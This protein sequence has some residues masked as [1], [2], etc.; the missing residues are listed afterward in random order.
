[1]RVRSQV[2]KR[3]A[4]PSSAT[5]SF[6]WAS[7]AGVSLLALLLG[8]AT[9]PAQAQWWLPQRKP[10]QPDQQALSDQCEK[11]RAWVTSVPLGSG[12]TGGD[13]RPPMPG[14]SPSA[15]RAL[16]LI[17]DEVFQRH[18]GKTYDQL[19][20]TDL[21]SFS[22][23]TGRPC[24]EQGRFTPLD[25]SMVHQLLN[26][27][28]QPRYAQQLIQHRAQKA[29][30]EKELEQLG[31][32]LARLR[33][34]EAGLKSLEALRQ[35]VQVLQSRADGER[36]AAA[37]KQLREAAGLIVPVVLRER[38]NQALA[39]AG[40]TDALSGLIRLQAQLD[41]TPAHLG[42]GL[43]ADDPVRAPLQARIHA[44][45]GDA[46]AAERRS[47]AALPGGL[48]GLAGGVEWQRQ[49]AGRWSLPL[50]AQLQ[51][52]ADELRQRRQSL[53]PALL[54]Q[55]QA[56]VLRAT[57]LAELQALPA[58]YLLSAEQQ[59]PTGQALLLAMRQRNELI[60]RNTA[61]GRPTLPGPAQPGLAGTGAPPATAQPALPQAPA[62]PGLAESPGE[63]SEEIMFDLVKQRFDQAAAKLRGL[64]E[65][66]RGN[67][68]ARGG[69]PVDAMLCL[70]INL[71]GASTGGSMGTPVKILSFAKL[72]CEKSPSLPGYN[73]E[74]E[75]KTSHPLRGQMGVI[76]GSLM[77]D[78][79]LGQARFV[80]RKEGWHMIHSGNAA[81]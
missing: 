30:V 79:G 2:L 73:C 53:L 36:A 44:L 4:G 29:W 21:E 31:V 17:S 56:E 78:G 39:G 70:G 15:A 32:E 48:D 7:R 43:A 41:G 9:L 13:S 14:M 18:F 65:Q 69:N 55:L 61:L 81:R 11:I 20:V 28:A 80:R 50:P 62:N 45:A 25:W 67:Q 33:P 64:Q 77:D 59:G 60:E 24:L 52:V 71:G 10:A 40:S 37:E 49:F 19:S 16:A 72:G 74:Y 8:L 54:P 23:A 75:A 76:M 63:P 68:A 47:L 66:C 38:V 35:R 57:S 42:L 27:S 12:A 26:S 34:D 46:A 22:R 5:A 51:A 1:M 58:R 6:G 3:S